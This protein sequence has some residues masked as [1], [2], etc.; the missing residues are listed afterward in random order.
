MKVVLFC[1]GMGTRIREYSEAVPKPMIPIGAQPILWHIM[2]YYSRH[3]HND[4]VLCLGYKANT[5]KE[6]FLNHKPQAF[7]DLIVSEY[8]AKVETLGQAREDWRVTLIDTGVWRNIGERLWAVRDQVKDEEMFFAN[9]SDGLSDVPLDEMIETFK[10]S[11]KVACFLAVHP[12]LTFHLAQIDEAGRVRDIVPSDNADMWINGGFF[13]F[14]PEI[15][16]Y[17]REGEELVLEPFKRLIE[18]DQLLAYKYEGFWRAMDTLRDRQVLEEMIEQGRMPW[19]VRD[20][21]RALRPH[22]N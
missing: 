8:G 16:D 1:G 13:I 21:T 4:F 14:K 7:S 2:D 20:Q 18:A 3:G 17:M 11:G 5:I 10:Q 6:F 12:M 9:Y 19:R 22:G 15:Y